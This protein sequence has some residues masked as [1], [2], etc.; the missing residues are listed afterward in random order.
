M[1]MKLS[2]EVLIYIQT[3]KTYF[4]NSKEARDYFI[5]DSDVEL[6]FQHLS[7]ISQ[8]NFDDE[9]EV[10]LNKEQFELLR[11]TILAITISKKTDDEIIEEKKDNI[12]MDIPNFGQICLN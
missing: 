12:F 8:K 10:M 4:A 11:K 2:P 5:G 6:F 7:E 1:I 3:V 9:G